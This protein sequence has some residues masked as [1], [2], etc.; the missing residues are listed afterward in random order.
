MFVCLGGF[1]CFVRFFCRFLY[2]LVCCFLGRFFLS[3]FPSFLLSRL[4]LFLSLF[5]SLTWSPLSSPLRSRSRS[6]LFL[7]FVSFRYF[8]FL[9]SFCR[10]FWQALSLY[11]FLFTCLFSFSS[12]TWCLPLVVSLCRLWLGLRLGLCSS[13]PFSSFSILLVLL[14]L[15]QTGCQVLQLW[16]FFGGGGF[17]RCIFTGC[18][19]SSSGARDSL[20]V[21]RSFGFSGY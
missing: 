3:F 5:M 16:L 21:V 11:L 2:L 1:A 7:V 14:S 4:F 18:F 15:R 6:S 12:V 9:S 19:L 20:V 17:G 13:H 8:S 10:L